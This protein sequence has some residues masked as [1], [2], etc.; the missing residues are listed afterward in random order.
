MRIT[1][2][3][4]TALV[5]AWAGLALAA[6]SSDPDPDASDGASPGATMAAE[7]SVPDVSG[8]VDEA[9]TATGCEAW[10]GGRVAGEGVLAGW[11]YTCDVDGDG[12]VETTLSVYSS[13]DALENDL[14]NVEAADAT[15]AIIK[16]DEVIIATNDPDHLAALGGMGE[17]VRELGS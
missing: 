4:P 2:G 15:A 7:E 8:I 14:A 1:R 17:V 10:A 13:G 6:C 5:A 11:A 3:I 12:V 9:R 16:G